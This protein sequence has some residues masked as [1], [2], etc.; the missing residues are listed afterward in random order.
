M[1]NV[2]LYEAPDFQPEILLWK[3]VSAIVCVRLCFRNVI[4]EIKHAN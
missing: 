1:Q 2:E 4:I 3:F